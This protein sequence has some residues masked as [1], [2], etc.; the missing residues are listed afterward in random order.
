MNSRLEKAIQTFSAMDIEDAEDPRQTLALAQRD[1]LREF[2][3]AYMRW[4]DAHPEAE[5]GLFPVEEESVEEQRQRMAGLRPEPDDDIR[6]WLRFLRYRELIRVAVA[7]FSGLDDFATTTA[8]RPVSEAAASDDFTAVSPLRFRE[9]YS[10]TSR[11]FGRGPET[12]RLGI[13]HGLR[14][15]LCVAPS[16]GACRSGVASSLERAN[17]A[18]TAEKDEAHGCF[19]RRVRLRRTLPRRCSATAGRR[20]GSLGHPL[21]ERT[22]GKGTGGPALERAVMPVEVNLGNPPAGVAVSFARAGEKVKVCALEFTSTEDGQHF[23]RRLEACCTHIL[24]RLPEPVSPSQVDHMLVVYRRDG[25]AEVYVNELEVR[26]EAR[27]TGAVGAGDRVTKDDVAEIRSLDLGVA[28]PRDAGFLFLFSVGWRKGLFYDLVPTHIPDGHPRDYEIGPALGRMYFRVLFQERFGLSDDDW[29]R[30]FLAQWFPFVGLRSSTADDLISHVQ[31]GVDPDRLVDRIVEETKAR[32]PRM[33]DSWA[34]RASFGPHMALLE[35]AIERFLA[36]DP[37]SCT[38][39]LFPRIEGILRRRHAELGSGKKPHRDNLVRT[40]T[41][42]AI[43]RDNDSLLLPRRFRDYLRKVYFAGFLPK[44]DDVKASR[45]SVGHG[46]AP[47]SA[48]DRKAAVLGLL[49]VDQLFYFLSDE[50]ASEAEAPN[51]AKGRI[52][53]G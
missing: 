42:S 35:H 9:Y 39:L 7:D 41:E 3:P 53:V 34:G 40:A 5:E 10:A 22:P 52:E 1:I 43:R 50:V 13:G 15:V 46:V 32:L 8:S 18:W 2:A 29:N 44:D 27:A 4:L 16:S 33:A 31:G 47:A 26:A 21:A 48:F 25:T 30:L 11:W 12:R 17:R 38:A 6:R 45:D 51:T 23:I 24:E 28:V 14:V 20:L 36:D 37:A 49:T 19:D